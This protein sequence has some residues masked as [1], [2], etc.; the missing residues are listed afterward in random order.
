[1]S[2][3]VDHDR[4]I[5]EQLADELPGFWEYFEARNPQF[6]KSTPAGPVGHLHAFQVYEAIGETITAYVKE[7]MRK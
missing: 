7:A 4:K 6:G 3:H 5:A 1:M 2:D